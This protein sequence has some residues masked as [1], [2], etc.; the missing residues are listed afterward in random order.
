MPRLTAA[1]LADLARRSRR[2]LTG[3]DDPPATPAEL[4]GRPRLD[5]RPV[6]LFVLGPKPHHTPPSYGRVYA[7]GLM[8]LPG[9]DPG[10]REGGGVRPLEDQLADVLAHKPPEEGYDLFVVPVPA[11][12]IDL[13]AHAAKAEPELARCLHR[14]GG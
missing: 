7:M 4:N 9:R 13:W 10:G 3:R 12:C 5:G 6:W 8:D 2:C 11:G 1:T 14:A